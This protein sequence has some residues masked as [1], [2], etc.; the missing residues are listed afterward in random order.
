MAAARGPYAAPPLIVLFSVVLLQVEDLKVQI[1]AAVASL[2]RGLAAN[3]SGR[4]S[5][6]LTCHG[7][8]SLAGVL[9]GPPSVQQP[10]LLE[11]PASDAG[12]R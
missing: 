7:S 4:T 3:V 1:L 6:V 2:D 8:S 9:Q 12:C 10:C 11:T 5:L